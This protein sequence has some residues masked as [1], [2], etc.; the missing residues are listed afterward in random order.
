MN[1]NCK[2][3]IVW[4]VQISSSGSVEKAM[5]DKPVIFHMNLDGNTT[6]RHMPFCHM[7]IRHSRFAIC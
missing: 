3:F 6:F 1:E 2:V 4:D 7:P 5:E